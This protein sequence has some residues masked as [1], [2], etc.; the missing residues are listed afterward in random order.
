M[1]GRAQTT[2]LRSLS[3]NPTTVAALARRLD[4]SRQAAH[5]TVKQLD[6]WNFISRPEE[7]LE[8]GPKLVHLTAEG[9]RVATH[10]AEAIEATETALEDR[11]GVGRMWA[12]RKVFS[13]LEG[14]ALDL[15]PR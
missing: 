10:L 14:V 8:F 13:H 15:K 7:T 11:L 6:A 12:L 4:V 1:M 2:A 9:E 3:E 5:Q